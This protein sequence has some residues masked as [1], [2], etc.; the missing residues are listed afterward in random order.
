MMGSE[1]GG[2]EGAFSYQLGGLLLRLDMR[3][4]MCR[5]LFG[6]YFFFKVISLSNY[7]RAAVTMAVVWSQ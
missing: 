3:E 4:F 6:S 2:V 1:G 7:N 5:Q